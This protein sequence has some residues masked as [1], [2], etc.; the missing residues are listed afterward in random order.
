MCVSL[1]PD[2]TEE[3]AISYQPSLCMVTLSKLETLG[4]YIM[5][6]YDFC[7][8]TV[9]LIM[10]ILMFVQF[11]FYFKS[12]LVAQC[13]FFFSSCIQICSH[14]LLL[15]QSLDRTDACVAE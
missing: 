10:N 11:V 13:R 8:P 1:N 7:H 15:A 2:V 9:G 3:E 14:P 6:H 5:Q 12:S 4:L